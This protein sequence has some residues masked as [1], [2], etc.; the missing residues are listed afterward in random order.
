MSSQRRRGNREGSNP[1]Q[2]KDGRWQVALRYTDDDGVS[3]RRTVTGKTPEDARNKARA[4]LSRLEKGL[5]ARDSNETVGNY[6]TRWID[7]TLAASD[8]KPT[9]QSLYSSL[10]RKHVVGSTLGAMPLGKVRKSHVDG[11]LA[12]LKRKGLAAS[13]RRT[14]Y[15][16]LSAVFADAVKDDLLTRNVVALSNRPKV[17]KEEAAFL[18]VEQVG[19][20]LE[21]AEGSRYR[22][23][24]EL[25][26]MTGMR[27]GEALALRWTDI[28]E[29]RSIIRVR[30]TLARQDGELVVT[31]TKS[32]KS[33]RQLPLSP[34][35]AKTLNGVRST[36]RQERLQAGSKWAST[37]FVFTTELGEPCDPRNAL[38][39]LQTAAHKAGIDG[40]GLHTLRHTG[41]AVAI[42][43]GTHLKVISELWGHSSIA[44]TGDV[45]GHVAPELAADAMA[46]L[47]DAFG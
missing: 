31:S 15:I 9:T 1:V 30:G 27:R 33:T 3:S 41:A 23:L 37:G 32:T 5:P 40:I 20:L 38:R 6:A 39:A 16:V 26:V 17:E 22:P 28:D 29:K 2:R 45:Y 12:G 44:I 18:T 11:W 13:T 7:T 14:S 34:K 8:R 47:G 10:V 19:A 24:F 42:A 4:A 25:L 21:A 46:A 43:N 35:V 36:Q